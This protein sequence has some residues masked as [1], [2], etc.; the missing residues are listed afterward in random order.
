[1]NTKTIKRIF[2]ILLLSFA[3]I[4]I[5]RFLYEFSYYLGSSSGESYV[6]GGYSPQSSYIYSYDSFTRKSLTSNVATEKQI[7]SGDKG[8]EINYDQKYEMISDIKSS[9]ADFDNDVSKVRQAV[10]DVKG[11]V[12]MEY[13]GGL[14]EKNNR[15]LWVSVGVTPGKF[16]LLVEE[17]KKIGSLTDFS[18]N[19]TDKTAEFR[20]YLAQREALDKTLESYKALKSQGGSIADLLVVEEKI[21]QTE[22]EIMEIGVTLGLY[23]ESRSLCTVEFTL[24]E[25][26]VYTVEPSGIRFY[27]IADS[28]YDAL[29]W[30]LAVYAGLVLFVLFIGF[31]ALGGAFI[32]SRIVGQPVKKGEKE[33]KDDKQGK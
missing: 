10:D 1:M 6:T 30:T 13:N 33:N 3:V 19:K 14:E 27:M 8:V 23:D 32:V 15:C 4:F 18:V 22:K 29:F 17:L 20:A 7:I 12:Q 21:I 26:S 16:D 28:A 31:A 9:S 24:G 5:L 2:I 25:Y 11:V